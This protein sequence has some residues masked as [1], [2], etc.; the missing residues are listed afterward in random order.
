MQFAINYDVITCGSCAF[1]FALPKSFVELREDDHKSFY[2]PSCE[3][4]RHW[5]AESD[6]ERLERQLKN[7]QECCTRYEE[8]SESLRRSNVALKGHNTRK[9]KQLQA[10]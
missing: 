6:E 5:P 3:S 2:C 9:K 7:V 4:R 1:Q 8:E 10:V